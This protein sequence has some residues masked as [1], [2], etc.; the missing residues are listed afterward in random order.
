MAKRRDRISRRTTRENRRDTAENGGKPI[1][2][3]MKVTRETRTFMRSRGENPATLRLRGRRGVRARARARRMAQP[4][5]GTGS[6]SP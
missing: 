6:N 4:S 2:A 1:Q 5:G 3:P